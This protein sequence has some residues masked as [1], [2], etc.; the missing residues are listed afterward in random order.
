[1]TSGASVPPDPG[2]VLASLGR[3][4][5]RDDADDRADDGEPV[6]QADRQADIERTTS[7]SSDDED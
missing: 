1:M 7:L 3:A 5:A 2:A 4:G 6:G